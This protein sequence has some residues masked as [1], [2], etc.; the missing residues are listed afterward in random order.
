MILN[1]TQVV[2]YMIYIFP[3]CSFW[4]NK[5]L[6][7][8]GKNKTIS[9]KQFERCYS[10]DVEE[11][12]GWAFL[13]CNSKSTLLGG[14]AYTSHVEKDV[15]RQAF[16]LFP[17]YLQYRGISSSRFATRCNS[18]TCIIYFSSY[19]SSRHS[20]DAPKF[21]IKEQT[22]SAAALQVYSHCISF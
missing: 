4:M 22:S 9:D 21:L 3:V 14:P 1:I 10:A 18:P 15:T 8:H 12:K 2:K 16:R 20:H 19:F 5:L 13:R 11:A 6:I 17:V 7:I